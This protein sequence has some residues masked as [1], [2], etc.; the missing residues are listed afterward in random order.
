MPDIRRSVVT[1]L[2]LGYGLLVATSIAVVSLVFYFGTMGVLQQNVDRRLIYIANREIRFNRDHPG[3]LA[4]EIDTQLGD[5]INSDTEIFQLLSSRGQRIVGNLDTWPSLPDRGPVTAHVL[6]YGRPALARLLRISLLDGDT[7]IVGWELSEQELIGRLVLRSLAAGAL[8]SLLLIFGGALFFRHL[9]EHPIAV[10]RRT[11]HEIEAGDLSRR[12]PV[13]SSDE[14]G[15]LAMDINRMLDRI[16]Q[17]MDGVLHVSNAIAHDL[18]TPLSRIRSRLEEA[19]RSGDGADSPGEA[20]VAAI[21]EI[22]EL[23]LVFEK[24]LQIAQAESGVHANA[25]EPVD[26]RR[27]A[28]DMADLYDASAEA[29]GV[30][31]RAVDGGPVLA[32]G[33]RNLIANALASLIDNAIKYSGPDSTV[34][35]RAVHA[36]EHVFLEVLDDG[37]GIPEAELPRVTTRFYRIDQSRNLPGNGLGLSIVSAIA[38]LHGGRLALLNTGRGLLARIVLPHQPAG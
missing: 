11:A 10:M 22:D 15:R 9:I 8:I 24:L 31:L 4:R 30:Q 16:E 36:G 18:R 32:L 37:P 12:I 21:G 13:A 5:S 6:R 33:D 1:Q 34:E 27:V 29:A 35:V 23:I 3:A 25:F 14:F 2:L 26:I 28:R 20:A 19:V 7:L 17:L 38:S